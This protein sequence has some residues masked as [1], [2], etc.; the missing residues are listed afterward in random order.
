[1]IPTEFDY[2]R[3]ASV[4]DA[5]GLLERHGDGAKLLAGGHSPRRR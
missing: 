1:M 3:P 5:V 4:A 2:E